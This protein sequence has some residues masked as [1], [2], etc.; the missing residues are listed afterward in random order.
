M[1]SGT[2]NS[3]AGQKSVP[4]AGR[5]AV[6]VL[7]VLLFCGLLCA[8]YFGFGLD[9]FGS[10]KSKKSEKITYSVEFSSVDPAIANKLI[11]G[12]VVRG[13][14]GDAFGTVASLEAD[15]PATI[16][17]IENSAFAVAQ[18]HPTNIKVI[19]N[20]DVTADADPTN[21]YSIRGTRI[22]VGAEYTLTLSGVT[23]TGKCIGLQTEQN[24][25][26]VGK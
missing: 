7:L 15:E 24:N 16:Y 14:S 3:N 12:A 2:H 19:I 4:T 23:L 17:K 11:Q 9:T 1:N 21:G 13:P 18:G 25:G 20:V 10:G 8:V 26:G 5:I 22:A 6:V